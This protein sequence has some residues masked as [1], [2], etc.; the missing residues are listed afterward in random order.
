[1]SWED[2]PQFNSQNVRIQLAEQDAALELASQ[3]ILEL[4][5]QIEDLT[6]QVQDLKK[7]LQKAK[8]YEK[9]ATSVIEALSVKR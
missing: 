4:N 7:A 8:D 9:M 3:E 5:A 6:D 1:M 2:H